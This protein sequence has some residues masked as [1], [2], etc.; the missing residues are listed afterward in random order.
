ML[1]PFPTG[2]KFTKI[3]R[4]A[5][6]CLI[7]L[8]YQGVNPQ[9]TYAEDDSLVNRP[10]N[11]YGLSGLLFTTAPYTLP[12][13]TVEAGVSIISENS[14]VPNYRISE[15]TVSFA[16]GV[17]GNAE[18]ACRSSYYELR[19]DPVTASAV[20]RKTGDLEVSYKWNFLAPSESSFRPALSVQ[21]AGMIP[22]QDSSD[23]NFNTVSQWGM[24]LGLSAGTE[25]AWGDH[26]VAIYADAEVNGKDPASQQ[27]RDF[28]EFAN[29]GILLPISKYQNL[30][31]LAEY[32][33][34]Y[35]KNRTLYDSGD[36]S[37]ITYGIRLVNERFNLTIGTQFLHKQNVSFDNSGRVIGL[38]SMK[39]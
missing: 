8:L 1:N 30:Q 21:V 34:V 18:F 12:L 7:L 13:N 4:I 35:G 11:I 14:E 26:V 10:V 28:F 5:A 29:A 31:M 24:R 16:M 23:R 9:S 19:E 37:G 39:F 2:A 3:S 22:T 25:I 15:Y 32:S 27:K 20:Q 33:L 6:T 17:P 36:Y 38:M